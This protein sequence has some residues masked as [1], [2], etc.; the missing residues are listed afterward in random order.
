[1]EEP[2]VSD[3]QQLPSNLPV[4][5]DDGAADHLPGAAMPALVLH[6]TGGNEVAL[7]QLGPGRTVVYLYPLSGRPGVDL[8]NGWDTIP[9]A[10]GCTPEACGF[11]DHHA[12]LKAAG[13]HAVYGLSSQS[14]DY[15][16]ELADRLGL[17]S[18]I[19]SDPELALVGALDLPTFEASGERLFSRLT[20]IV[21]DGRIEH[22]FYPIFPPDQHA[23]EVL[24][25]LRGRAAV[26]ARA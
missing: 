22:A 20:L 10:R 12:D 19:L 26:E 16:A 7:D 23:A 11:R 5:Q 6:D 14:T 25:W 2:D 1:V 8:P 13:A 9:G 24:E 15:Q 21:T 17:P 4:P 3:Y 18:S